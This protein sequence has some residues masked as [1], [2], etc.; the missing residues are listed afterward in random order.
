MG[1]GKSTTGWFLTEHLQRTGIVARFLP[2][3]PTRDRPNHPLRMATGLP[4]PFAP[5]RDLTAEEYGE[6]SLEKWR[7]FVHEA[8]QS[9]A[10]TVCDGL[11]FHGNMTDLLVMDAEAAVLHRYV[12]QVIETIQALSP[13]VIYYRHADV[14]QALRVVCDTR[15]SRWEAYQVTWKVASPY[16]ARRGLRGF[17]GLVQLYRDYRAICDDLFARLPLPKLAILNEGD[18]AA[19]YRDILAFLDLAAP[20]PTA[21]PAA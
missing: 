7:T 3:G 11:L 21:P 14:A 1:A 20:P 9:T 6:R 19:Y 15:G 16:G 8:Q 2:E 5:W 12:A 13:V 17:D 4:H 18:W 10:V